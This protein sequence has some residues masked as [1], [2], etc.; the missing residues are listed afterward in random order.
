[1]RVIADKNDGNDGKIQAV[2]PAH[3][4][5]GLHFLNDQI[6]SKLDQPTTDIR[7]R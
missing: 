4:C 5:C 7:R 2:R 6:L 3:V 1:L